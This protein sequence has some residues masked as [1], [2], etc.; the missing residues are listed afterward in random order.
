MHWPIALNPNGNDPVI[1]LR[2]DGTRDLDLAWDIRDTWKQLEALL[3]KGQSFFHISRHIADPP[4]AESR[5]LVYPISRSRSSRS[6]SR[7]SRSLLRRVS[8]SCTYITRTTPSSPTSSPK[9]S[10]HR[11][12]RLL[13]RQTR[14]SSATQP[15][16][17]SQRSTLLLLRT[18]YWAGTVG[19]VHCVVAPHC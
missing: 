6:S 8:S 3:K 2:P 7:L 18:Y 13:V 19:P 15:S 9:A 12:T 10:S 14:H 1:P 11:H 17:G 4:Q 16:S 5:R